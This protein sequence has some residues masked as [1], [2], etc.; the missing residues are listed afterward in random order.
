MVPPKKYKYF[1]T[2]NNQ[3]FLDQ[4]NMSETNKNI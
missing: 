4:Q 2:W 3:Q 1:F